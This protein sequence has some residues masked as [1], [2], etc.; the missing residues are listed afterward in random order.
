MLEVL[1]GHIT[2][3]CLIRR[4]LLCALSSVYPYMAA[5]LPTT[6]RT[7]QSVRQELW[8]IRSLLLLLQRDLSSPWHD[9][10]GVS[11]ASEFG[12]G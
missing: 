11:D 2:W 12:V 10:V 4:E 8:L 1:V 7:W 5:D 9:V 3:A 6:S